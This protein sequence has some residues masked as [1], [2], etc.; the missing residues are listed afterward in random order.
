MIIVTNFAL[1]EFKSTRTY[2]LEQTSC[3]GAQ[4]ILS[5]V[6]RLH[7]TTWKKEGSPIARQV[8]DFEQEVAP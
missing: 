8:A 5:P 3:K 2:Q 4:A 1:V 7:L 6:S